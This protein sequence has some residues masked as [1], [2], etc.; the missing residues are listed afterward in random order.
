MVPLK[1]TD[2]GIVGQ[3]G[4]LTVGETQHTLTASGRDVWETED[5]A[6]FAYC[7]VE[8]DFDL[9]V[10]IESLTMANLYTKA[11]LMARQTLSP[12]SRNVFFAAFGDNGPRRNNNGSCEFQY[13]DQE[14]GE[15]LAI[16]P[17]KTENGIPL[18]PA[19]YPD[20]W[21]R[22]TRFGNEFTASF[23]N[24][25]LKWREY[26]KHE[27][28]LNKKIFVGVCVTAHNNEDTCTCR[29]SDFRLTQKG[30]D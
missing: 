25:G 28:S 8:G 24:N 12:D 22:L 23:S 11:G 30:A 6:H 1:N 17:I 29:F 10:R 3:M 13:R 20:N 18:F 2:I 21:L 5:S 14:G 27:L 15:S 7:E 9:S 4:S 16:Y 26:G 19:K